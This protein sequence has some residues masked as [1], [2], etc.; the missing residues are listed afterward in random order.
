MASKEQIM[1]A[2]KE[3]GQMYP[4]DI[5]LPLTEENVAQ[6]KEISKTGP[7]IDRVSAESARNT[8]RVVLAKIR[9]IEEEGGE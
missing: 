1:E 5:W 7:L 3:V 4:E 8:I 6:I 9:S 2:I